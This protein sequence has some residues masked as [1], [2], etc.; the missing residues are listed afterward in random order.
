MGLPCYIWKVMD[1]S[2]I[3]GLGPK[4]LSALEEAGIHSLPDLLYN[5]PRTW[6]DRTRVDPIATC[7]PDSRVVLVGTIVRAG[8]LRGRRS[9]FS[10]TLRDESGSIELLFFS[11]V[12]QLS[13]RLE[14]GSRWVVMGKVSKFRNLQLVHPELQPMD[15]GEDFSGGMTPIYTI[16]ESMR[17]QRMENRFFVKLYTQV[18]KLPNLHLPKAA[19]Q[20]LTEF[21]GLRP[22]LDN[23]RRLHL[24]SSYGEAMQGRRQLKILELLPFCLRMSRRRRL[25]SARGR[26]RRLDLGLVMNARSSLPFVLTDAQERSL[27]RILAG[28]GGK[29]QF[30]ALLQGDVGSGKTVVAM[31]A[32]LAVCGAGEQTALMVPTDILARQHY[33][34]LKP[35]FDA[36]GLRLGLLLGAMGASERRQL[37]A[38][39]NM[40]LVNAVIGTHALYSADVAF[41]SLGFAIID[42]Q[43]RFGVRQRE[44][45]LA[46]G[47]A[48]DL[49]VMSA[50]PIPRSLAMTLYG[51]LEAIVLAE[52]PPGRKPV[53]TRLVDPAKREDMKAFVLQEA[54]GG[55]RCYWVV[56]RVEIADEGETLSVAEVQEELQ[57]F[58]PSWRI[59][60]VH[61]QMDES[62]RDA[63]LTRF[64]AG[65]T[66]V[67]VCTTVVEVGVNVPAANIMVI[68]QPDRFGLAQ[69]HQLRGRV[70]RGSAQAW[71]FLNCAPN[72]TARE[73][74]EGF[75]STEDG[76]A[77]AEMD[78]RE[79]GAGNLEGSE[80]S[81]SWVFRW[82]DWIED[83][84]LIEKVLEL[85]DQLLDNKPAFPPEVLQKL[86]DWY[87]YLPPASQ[88]DGVH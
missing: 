43:H 72:H 41:A 60:V 6:L 61:G 23:L 75:A 36:A 53:K 37:L 13:K 81:G 26:E 64:A 65:E 22:V 57:N 21:L 14:A 50:T 3:A 29:S 68:D 54:L 69:L 5:I 12:A 67:I 28:L 87:Q 4:R 62:E 47:E 35:Y 11:G 59:G 86:Q 48:P 85:S 27:E 51:D 44:A 83:Q 8:V 24:P 32:M 55:N 63:E 16:T 82:F 49:L 52:K 42:E 18:F 71:C 20:E 9:R 78:M 46:K 34:S 25:L 84:E 10:A 80:Q 17:K 56:S 45:L 39:L 79:R 40:G 30:H 74:L 7:R 58:S 38:E 2:G 70:G 88:E 66:Q 33:Q 31:L 15:E 76:F 1:L 19:P 73:R 77:I